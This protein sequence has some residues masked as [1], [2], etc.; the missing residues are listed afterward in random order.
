MKR[1][2]TFLALLAT[3]GLALTIA[4]AQPKDV[5]YKVVAA[6]GGTTIRASFETEKDQGPQ[7]LLD[8]ELKTFMNPK[9]NTAGGIA[10]LFL[11]FPRPMED[12][13][14]VALGD[15]DKFFNYY[16]QEARFYID[17]NG[18]GEYDRYVGQVTTLGGGAKSRG[19][20]LFEDKPATAY[21]LEVRVVK[22]HTGASKRA[23][24]LNELKLLTSE[25]KWE[26]ALEE[27]VTKGVAKPLSISPNVET[28]TLLLDMSSKLGGNVIKGGPYQQ[29]V[30]Y[31]ADPTRDQVAEVRWKSPKSKPFVEWVLNDKEKPTLYQF[32]KGVV[33]SIP[34][35]ASKM[36][37]L[38]DI[39]VRV[40]DAKG[41]IFQ[42]GGKVAAKDGWQEVKMVL[43]PAR[44][45]G[46]W[47][48]GAD[49]K[50]T[51]QEPVQLQTLT[52]S[53]ANEIPQGAV[54]RVGDIK[55]NA[56]DADK[57]PLATLMKQFKGSLQGPRK[58]LVVA[59]DE[60]A[61]LKLKV[62]NEADFPVKGALLVDFKSYDGP[63]TTWNGGAV[64]LAPGE[65]KSFDVNPDL[66][67]R[68]AYEVEFQLKPTEGEAATFG[69]TQMALIAPAGGRDW[70]LG[71]DFGFG[72]GS[73][74]V[75]NDV[76][77]VAR[78]IGVDWTRGGGPFKDTGAKVRP[79][80]DWLNF[81]EMDKEQAIGARYN[82]EIQ[83]LLGYM[84]IW[85]AKEGYLEK[86]KPKT[87]QVSTLAPRPEPWREYIRTI[88]ERYKGQ[89]M[90]YEIMNEVD[91]EGF[92]KGTVDDYL[93]VLKIAHEEFKKANPDNIVMTSGFCDG[94][95]ARRQVAQPQDARA[96]DEG[97]L[98][99]F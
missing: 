80:G 40:K 59:T 2:T 58:S 24:L 83:P 72:I 63:T 74:L 78:M 15:S 89:P 91:L 8:D 11:R 97:R 68:G 1:K 44:N 92:F 47:G 5:A 37:G 55:R 35:D 84:P 6:P 70:K 12:L 9:P 49:G 14:G 16:P 42:W 21:G 67:L 29:G 48:G 52:F 17:T 94:R 69:K 51:V 76:A 96:R 50:G 85:A 56:F 79:K 53:A 26:K 65:S 90:M 66:G 98:P 57:I 13:A 30:G 93:E 33:L 86:Y 71:E 81:K 45:A 22:Q 31:V 77:E 87:W 61:K 28:P 36:P 99:V 41:E 19:E 18:D 27:P 60:V 46:N 73:A 20:Y 38:K 23:Y 10:S 3:S 39:G 54:V 75:N 32:D 4:L 62:S 34:V 64:E 25:Q 7:A 95:A 43:D 82:I 88:A